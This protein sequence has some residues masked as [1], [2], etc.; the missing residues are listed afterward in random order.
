MAKIEDFRKH[1]APHSAVQH[2]QLQSNRS[3]LFDLIHSLTHSALLTNYLD[4][5]V[6]KWVSGISLVYLSY[7][8]DIYQVYFNYILGIYQ[9]YHRYILD[10]P[11][12]HLGNIS[13]ISLLFLRYIF[14]I[15]W[16]YLKYVLGIPHGYVSDIS[17]TYSTRTLK[18]VTNAQHCILYWQTKNFIII[19]KKD[20]IINEKFQLISVTSWG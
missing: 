19:L 18:T 4:L 6:S 1:S 12:V 14:G 15:P 16:A 17:Q 11:I 10:I 9:V 13:D 2:F 8:A 20:T 7:L 5:L 3:I